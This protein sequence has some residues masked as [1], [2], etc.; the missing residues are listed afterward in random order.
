MLIEYV[1]LKNNHH[2]CILLG[3]D[4]GN[5]QN[6]SCY[7]LFILM[8][9][10]GNILYYCMKWIYL[11]QSCPHETKL[12]NAHGCCKTVHHEFA[13][14]PAANSISNL[15]NIIRIKPYSRNTFNMGNI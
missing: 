15:H 5:T 7:R 2:D 11:C 12:P 14:W 13:L 4:N 8:S 10:G 1:R 9:M 3:S 6:I